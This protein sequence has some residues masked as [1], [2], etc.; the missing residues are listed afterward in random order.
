[1]LGVIK[2]HFGNDRKHSEENL[3]RHKS[4]HQKSEINLGIKKQ[5]RKS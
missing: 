2:K 4:S 1:M 5:K 3:N